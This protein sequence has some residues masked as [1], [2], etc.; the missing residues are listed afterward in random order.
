MTLQPGTQDGKQI[1]LRQQGMKMLG[2]IGKG[3]MIIHVKCVLPQRVSERQ[4]Q[5]LLDFVEEEKLTTAA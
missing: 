2:R 4:R 1:K 5:L 3:D